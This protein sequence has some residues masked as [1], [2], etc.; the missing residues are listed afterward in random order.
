[1]TTIDSDKVSI[2][3]DSNEILYFLNDL[4]HYKPLFPA[5]RISDWEAD[6]KHL[7]FKIQGGYAID[8]YLS[9]ESTAEQTIL[10]SG[11][12]SPIEFELRP[13]IEDKGEH[14]E[15]YFHFEGDINPMLKLMVMKPLT[16]LFN[17]MSKQL[18]VVMQE[19]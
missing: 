17:Y 9:E 2:A 12:K 3:K 7:Y 1:M 8:L 10:K 19:S 15:C 4:R 5:D 6:E 16:N 11:E 18:G 13:M 14:R